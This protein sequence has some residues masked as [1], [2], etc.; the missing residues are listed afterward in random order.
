MNSSIKRNTKL[1]MADFVPAPVIIA[2]LLLANA[3]L[4]SAAQTPGVLPPF[5][6]PHGKTYGEWS[7]AWWKWAMDLPVQGHPFID[8]PSFDV[9]QGQSG[10]VWFLGS[11]LGTIERTCTIPTG[12]ALFI[13]MN[14]AEASN[15]E[16]LGN[17]ED[18]QR[19][20][21]RWLADHAVH[22]DR[23]LGSFCIID[24]VAVRNTAEYRVQSPQFTFTAPTPWIFGDVGGA[25]TSVADGY[26]VMIAPLSKGKHT[27]RFGESWH[28]S[29]AEGDG[30][31]FDAYFDTTYHITVE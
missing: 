15:L 26:Y 8:G 4:M 29:V 7:A 23:T 25:G 28:F 9:S 6:K 19:A 16:G 12:T 18:E 1:G 27:I 20:T 10:Q 11:P 14:T 21:A 3:T 24:G 31:D 17:T 5:S 22:A 2:A 30:F 13:A